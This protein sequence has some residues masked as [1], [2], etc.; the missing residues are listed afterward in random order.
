MNK[1]QDRPLSYSSI[2]S[3]AKS[4]N[5][6]IEYW[7]RK[8]ESTP[9]MLKGTLIHTLI[10]EPEE[11]GARY[12]ILNDSEIMEEIGGK[13]PRAT[14]KYKE[15]KAD[16]LAENEGKEEVT[17]EL[18]SEVMEVVSKVYKLD[19]A[20]KIENTEKL[21][22]FDFNGVPFKGFVD[23]E[24]FD[25]IMDVKTCQDASP[26]AFRRDIV[27]FSYHW[28]AALYTHAIPNKD[29]YIVAV[30]TVAPFNIQVYKLNKLFLDLGRQQVTEAVEKFKKWDGT[31]Q[32]YSE[33]EVLEINP[34]SWAF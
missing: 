26:A 8:R 23:A 7:E 18:Y 10:L 16:Q 24:G 6:L 22:E 2:K 28:Q 27:K 12:F 15:W 29:F 3:F 11:F 9:A 25:F 21:I 14:K 5:H 30:E 13:N 34:P 31:P 20:Q 17:E 4:P 32:S 1:K 19:I 33:G